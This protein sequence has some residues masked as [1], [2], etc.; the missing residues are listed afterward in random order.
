[1]DGVILWYGYALHIMY[2]KFWEVLS[3]PFGKYLATSPSHGLFP[4]V[5]NMITD[6]RIFSIFRETFQT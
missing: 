2:A 1:M 5:V 3:S 4:K 6:N